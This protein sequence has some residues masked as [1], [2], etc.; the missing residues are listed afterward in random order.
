MTRS[1]P[2]A[3]VWLGFGLRALA[4]QLT[5]PDCLSLDGVEPEFE[6]VLDTSECLHG[7][8]QTALEC[9]RYNTSFDPKRCSTLERQR[10]HSPTLEIEGTTHSLHTDGCFL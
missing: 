4:E 2:L 1:P 3:D 7:N 10:R 8:W 5:W 6:V 9:S